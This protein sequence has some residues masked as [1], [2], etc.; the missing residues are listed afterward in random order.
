VSYGTKAK[1][2]FILILARKMKRIENYVSELTKMM[3]S[4]KRR[5]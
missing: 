4:L 3:S 2:D 1:E 5:F